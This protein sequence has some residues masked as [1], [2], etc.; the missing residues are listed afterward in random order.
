MESRRSGAGSPGV[1]ARTPDARALGEVLAAAEV[2]VLVVARNGEVAYA[3]PALYALFGATP[4]ARP[5]DAPAA[6]RIRLV[7]PARLDA[8]LAEPAD[9]P[10]SR[11]DLALVD[12]R[13]LRRVA[14]PA[15]G[16]ARLWAVRDRTAEVA[17]AA[18]RADVA[19]LLDLYQRAPCGF[20]SIDANGVFLRMNDTELRWLGYRREEVVGRISLPDLLKPED[21]PVF[22]SRMAGLIETGHVAE[23]EWEFRRADGTWLPVLVT[24]TAVRTPDGRFQKSRSVV[25]DMT[26]RKRAEAALRDSE[27][28]HRSLFETTPIMIHSVDRE[29][30]LV[31]VSDCWLKTLGYA[32]EEVIGR[33]S[34][35]FLTAESRR[36]AETEV[37]P[38]FFQTGTAADV[39]YQVV[40]RDGEVRDVELHATCER[41]AVGRVTR[42]LAVMIDITERL[43][44]ER[45]LARYRAH[46]EELVAERTSALETSNRELETFSYSVSHD[47]RAP[48]RA[49]TSFS[50]L[51][52]TNHAAGL[53]PTGRA[54]LD[55]IR[56]AAA[57]QN[58]LIEDLLRLSQV[59]RVEMRR[60][61]VD[62]AALARTVAAELQA[63]EPARRV[64]V[65]IDPL[66]PAE[67]D[68][69]LLRI[70]FENLLS[71]AW[72]FTRKRP[73]AH[74]SVYADR[75]EAGAVIY[76]VQ[77]DGAGFD[78][79]HADRLF[80]PFSRLHPQAE[81]EGT[82]VGLATVARV[83]ARHGGRIW[84][85]GGIDRGAT[86]SFTLG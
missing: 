34:T 9:A 22:E 61:P 64:E 80:A 75:A 63:A 66:P 3:N 77:D 38:R 71:N 78:M 86:V 18:A 13:T 36:Y 31:A 53:D 76:R 59:G 28:R 83:V 7:D 35:E 81:F 21:R 52:A 29:G 57:R 2:G 25:I 30:R 47:L 62:L 1:S 10:E 5:A 73:V 84:A 19:D 24:A 45:E 37:L 20:H 39:R 44:A 43:R 82:G 70:L 72:K 4:P 60:E 27:E 68:P 50:E 6:L 65:R 32:R 12:G 55:R 8:A 46:L 56:A 42:S 54:L 48:L 15:P 33:K 16:L 51:L 49:I 26:A 14:L 17:L 67:G 11:E 74:V 85:E 41:D 69:T 23:A 58:Q 40:R 79:A